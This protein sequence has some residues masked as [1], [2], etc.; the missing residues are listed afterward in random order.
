MLFPFGS[1][2]IQNFW[3]KDMNFPIDIVWISEGKVA[4]F[5]RD[6]E[7]QPGA[8]LW[9]LTIYTSPD[10]VDQVLEVPAGT[11]A[12]DGLK[13]GDSVLLGASASE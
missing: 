6:A 9:K 13:M 7:P 4:G 5:V 1:G 2:G 12:K 8:P 11:V 10:N 3:M